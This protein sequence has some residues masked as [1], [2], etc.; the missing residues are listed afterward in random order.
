MQALALVVAALGCGSAPGGGGSTTAP[1]GER[2]QTPPV[3]VGAAC[4][5]EGEVHALVPPL[6]DRCDGVRRGSCTTLSLAGAPA[7][8]LEEAV[9]WTGREIILWG[10]CAAAGFL[11]AGLFFGAVFFMASL[12]AA[13]S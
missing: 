7:P 4:S 10:G 5:F 6:P 1:P 2:R 13:G 3:V 9:V 11:A 8:R 12:R